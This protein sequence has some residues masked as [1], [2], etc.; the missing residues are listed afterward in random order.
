MRHK[1]MFSKDIIEVSSEESMSLSDDD[2]EELPGDKTSQKSDDGDK[3]KK[4]NKAI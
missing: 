4:K 1:M 3:K 2:V